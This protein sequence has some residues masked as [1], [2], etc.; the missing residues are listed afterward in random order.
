[1]S[2]D[3]EQ[4]SQILTAAF[5]KSLIRFSTVAVMVI[6]CWT[7]FTPFLPILLWAIVLS[8]ALFPARRFL[9]QKLGWSIKRSSVVITL[10][11]VLMIGTPV[12]MVGNSFATK[13]VDAFENIQSGQLEVPPP[14]ANVKSWPLVGPSIHD[15]WT[16]A[17]QD[18]PS[19]LEKRQPM[20]KSTVTW[21]VDKAGG[22]ASSAFLLIGAVIIAGIM[23]TWAEVAAK[24]IRRVFISFSDNQK[25]PELHALTTATIR[26]VAIG[27][28][29]IAFLTAIV[30][31]A[32]VALAGVPGAPFLTIAA[33]LFAIMQLPVTL[34][35]LV[36][37]GLLWS[38]SE[39]STLYNTLFTVLILASSIVDNI[40]KPMVLG[41]GLDVP[42]PVVL[43][44]AIGGMMSGGILGMFIGAV[45]LSAGYQVFM[46]WV[47]SENSEPES[48]KST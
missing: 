18:L 32:I 25:G 22:V 41:R 26:Q 43:I 28:I 40:L 6:V 9:E 12:F 24:S 29:G 48:S 38:G 3:N 1:M 39:A 37:V 42:M 8:I 33:L 46:A 14:S 23:L 15:V 10:L 2:K 31:G 13:T 44:G 21:L 45:F 20:I 5:T 47:D 11:G 30:F 4:L 17:E 19:F 7:A 34:I 35:A 27:V 36:A 16:E